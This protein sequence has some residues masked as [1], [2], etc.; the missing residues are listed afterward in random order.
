MSGRRTLYENLSS[1]L[2]NDKQDNK[3]NALCWQVPIEHQS[4]F[5]KHLPEEPTPSF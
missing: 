4:A 2:R 1:K 3:I 5:D